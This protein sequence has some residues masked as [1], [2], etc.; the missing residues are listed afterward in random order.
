MSSAA[1]KAHIRLLE[2][3]LPRRTHE[4]RKP[5]Y[6]YNERPGRRRDEDTR[7]LNQKIL[8][9]I[10]QGFANFEIAAKLGVSPATVGRHRL[11]RV[12]LL[13]PTA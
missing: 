1:L 4:A 7:A 12:K 3:D 13:K 5:E 8:D 9:L 11:G 2:S 6:T 10:E